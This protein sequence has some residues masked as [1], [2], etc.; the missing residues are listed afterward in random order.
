MIQKFLY[1]VLIYPRS[2]SSFDMSEKG[3]YCKEFQET[4]TCRYT[5]CRFPHTI[6]AYTQKCMKCDRQITGIEWFIDLQRRAN[7]K[8]LSTKEKSLNTSTTNTKSS[9]S[10]SDSII[11]FDHSNKYVRLPRCDHFYCVNC[12]KSSKCKC[13]KKVL[14]TIQV[15]NFC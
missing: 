10:I 2:I 6:R 12:F 4:G 1:L 11:P 15:Y 13:G 5:P 9:I 8:K 14:K 3:T 7:E